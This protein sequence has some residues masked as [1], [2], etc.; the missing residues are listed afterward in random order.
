MH[1]KKDGVQSTTVIPAEKRKTGRPKNPNTLRINEDAES[2]RNFI[3]RFRNSPITKVGYA[4]WLRR[5]MVYCNECQKGIGVGDNPDK[6]LFE[7][8]GKKIQNIIK[9]FI[10]NQ[11]DKHLSPKSVHSYYLAIKHFYESNEIALNWNIIKDYVGGTTS[12]RRLDM[13]YTYEE[14]HRM[15]DKADERKRVC[16]LLLTSTGMRRGALSQ[17]RFGDLNWI[18]D[19]RIYQIQVYSGFPEEY[20]TFCTQECASAINSYLDFRRRNGE[21]ITEDSY[22]I[23][24]QFDTRPNPLNKSRIKVSDASD[25]PEKHKVSDA[26][27]EHMIYQLVY[28]SGIRN[29]EDRVKRLGDRHRNM[30]AHSFRK[31]FEN[32]CLEAGLDPFYVSVLMG[33]KAGIGVERHYYRP[34][35]IAGENSLLG[36][37]VNKAMPYLTISNE[38]RLALK[39]RE[40]ELRMKEDEERFRALVKEREELTAATVNQFSHELFKMKQEIERLKRREG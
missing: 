20:T 26:D 30:A 40:L 22:L 35:S 6:L 34:E 8:D 14:I 36:L 5:F 19:Y 18:E 28:D 16:I 4:D 10:D 15:L 13:P 31:F 1:S 39:N 25:P 2:F 37:Y 29:R 24:K 27:I 21:N 38:A 32:K 23:R 11:Y 3:R 17:L 9:H 7:G 12:A 33:H